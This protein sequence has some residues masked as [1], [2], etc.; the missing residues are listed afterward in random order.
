MIELDTSLIINYGTKRVC[1]QHPEEPG[2]AVKIPIGGKKEGHLS[3]LK[4]LKGYCDLIKNHHDL[5]F[6][7]HCYGIVSTNLGKGLLT[8]S[9]RDRNGNHSQSIW[10]IIVYQDNCDISLIKNIAHALCEKLITKDIFLFDLNLKNI[11]LKH[12][13]DTNWLPVIIDLKGRYDNNEFIPLSSYINFL[14][15]IK[16][17]R[18]CSQLVSRISEFREMRI[19]LQT[20]DEQ[21]KK[22]FDQTMKW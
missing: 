4:E 12:K 20:I 5:L 6:I 11:L 22:K 18:R 3:N 7:S 15:R 1:F 2:L 16:L 13:S 19:E 9:I 10:D 21:K 14:A 8:D 17:K